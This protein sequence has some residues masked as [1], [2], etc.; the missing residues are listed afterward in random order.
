VILDPCR[1]FVLMSFGG[2]VTL[3]PCA[4]TAERVCRPP[5]IHNKRS[6]DIPARWPRRSSSP[7]RVALRRTVYRGRT[8]GGYGLAGALRQGRR[9]AGR[10]PLHVTITQLS[11]VTPFAVWTE[12]WMTVEDALPVVLALPV[13]DELRV[14]CPAPVDDPVPNPISANSD[15][16]MNRSAM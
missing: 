11:R 10:P 6:G 12:R 15:K 14:T 2:R 5:K 7:V 9:C 3:V 8:G 4:L 13:A 1:R 16:R